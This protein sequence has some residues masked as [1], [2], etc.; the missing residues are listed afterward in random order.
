MGD[1]E[2]HRSEAIL[3]AIIGAG[4]K[5]V[6][7]GTDGIE[8]GLL[9]DS[10]EHGLG[11]LLVLNVDDRVDFDVVVAKFVSTE[12]WKYKLDLLDDLAPAVNRPD[13]EEVGQYVDG[14]AVFTESWSDVE[15][16]KLQ[17]LEV[18]GQSTGFRGG[19]TAPDSR[20]DTTVVVDPAP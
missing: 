18:V 9:K 13:S 4:G 12:V 20:D 1:W 10:A 2:L 5:A 16:G 7:P 3:P 11:L 8:A 6:H 17:L 15:A 14:L 19:W